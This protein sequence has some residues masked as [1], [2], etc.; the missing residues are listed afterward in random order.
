VSRLS[1]MQT[2]GYM[3]ILRRLHT[4]FDLCDILDL[5]SDAEQG[6][7]G[8][9]EARI[10][11][12]ISEVI[13]AGQSEELLYRRLAPDL[14]IFTEALSEALEIGAMVEFLRQI[15]PAVLKPMLRFVVEGPVVPSEETHNTNQARNIQFE[16]ALGAQLTAAG[17]SVVFAEPDLRCTVSDLAFFV[18]C[19]RI[20][21][22]TR[23][24]Q[25]I[26][27]ALHQLQR[28]L[29]PHAELGGIIAI[30][31]SRALA[32]ED[33]KPVQIASKASGLALLESQIDGFIQQYE[34]TWEKSDAAQGI[35][36]H[37]RAAFTNLETN[38]IEVGT[39]IVMHW[40]PSWRLSPMG[41]TRF[42]ASNGPA[43]RTRF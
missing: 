10:R 29:Q 38:K 23:L 7:F 27:G 34:A 5:R 9:Y 40:D 31:L 33:G 8:I 18:A 15:P 20:Y 4:F 43:N 32:T 37:C 25:R 35:L 6:R 17:I 19:K 36:F 39:F 28:E 26:E 30:S 12:L 13:R 1:G 24:N 14:P 21:S 2:A 41:L 16:L 11:H 42:S 3:E 22:P